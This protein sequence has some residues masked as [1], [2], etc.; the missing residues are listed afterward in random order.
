[1]LAILAL[2]A[3][4]PNVVSKFS[5]SFSRLESGKSDIL[6]GRCTKNPS[7]SDSSRM[8]PVKKENELCVVLY[9]ITTL[10]FCRRKTIVSASCISIDFTDVSSS[11]SSQSLM[12]ESIGAV[13]IDVSSGV[14][15]SIPVVVTQ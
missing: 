3:K 7:P 13:T 9:S 8:S 5:G 12:M 4:S 14:I 10:L 15:W 1:M 6:R 2:V 11:L